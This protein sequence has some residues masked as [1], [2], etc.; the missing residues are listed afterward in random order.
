MKKKIIIFCS[1]KDFSE[2]KRHSYIRETGMSGKGYSFQFIVVS[3][4]EY[5]SAIEELKK[6]NKR[7]SLSHLYVIQD[8]KSGRD[9][10]R[11]IKRTL[12]KRFK[13]LLMEMFEVKKTVIDLRFKKKTELFGKDVSDRKKQKYIFRRVS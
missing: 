4:A 5:F 7:E 11:R 6:I 2:E 13:K 12:N 8:Y 9:F 3:Q 1:Q 10:S